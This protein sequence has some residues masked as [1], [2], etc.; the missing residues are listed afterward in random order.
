MRKAEMMG[1]AEIVRQETTIK[2]RM[3]VEHGQELAAHAKRLEEVGAVLMRQAPTE[4]VY[5]AARRVMMEIARLK[6]TSSFVEKLSAIDAEEQQH[7]LRV[8]FQQAQVEAAQA[9][10]KLNIMSKAYDEALALCHGEGTTPAKQIKALRTEVAALQEKLRASNAKIVT[11]P[12]GQTDERDELLRQVK[13][14][15]SRNEGQQ[16]QIEALRKERD[17]LRTEVTLLRA[18]VDTEKDARK[19]DVA[20]LGFELGQ[21]KGETLLAAARRVCNAEAE[22]LKGECVKLRLEVLE[23]TG[24]S[25]H[26]KQCLLQKHGE[27]EAIA[28]AIGEHEGQT[29]EEAVLALVAERDSLLTARHTGWVHLKASNQT[30][31]HG[32]AAQIL[33][34]IVHYENSERRWDATLCEPCAPPDE[35]AVTVPWPDSP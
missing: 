11:A 12:K 3:I 8:K 31:R 17:S 19:V 32:E 16:Q 7:A 27:L 6:N 5:D 30:P 25:K 14:S 20:E 22:R 33:A 29:D 26:H 2:Q 28:K 23:L 13:L 10:T 24:I 15:A 35:T 21:Q 4:T 1:F 9:T 18:E 34:F